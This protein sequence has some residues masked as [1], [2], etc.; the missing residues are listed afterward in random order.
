L[1][2]GRLGE[3]PQLGADLGVQSFGQFVEHVQ[4]AVVPAALMAG[5]GEDLVQRRPQAQRAVADR[6]QRRLAQSAL[7]K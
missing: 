6:Q 3:C 1:S 7:S 2:S 4:L 5:G